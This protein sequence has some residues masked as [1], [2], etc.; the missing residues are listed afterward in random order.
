MFDP[1][2]PVDAEHAKQVEHDDQVERDKR[3]K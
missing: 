2:D 1:F 3:G